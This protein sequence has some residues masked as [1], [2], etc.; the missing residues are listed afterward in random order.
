MPDRETRTWND[1]VVWTYWPKKR[2]V[3]KF[4]IDILYNNLPAAYKSVYA[5]NIMKQ[6]KADEIDMF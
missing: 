4:H 3:F 2:E 6:A 1:L 5:Y